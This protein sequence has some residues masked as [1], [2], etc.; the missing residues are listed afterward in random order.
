MSGWS[1]GSDQVQVHVG[2]QTPVH[3]CTANF[4][5]NQQSNMEKHAKQA[6]VLG[7]VP[8]GTN[9]GAC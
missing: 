4:P 8:A 3:T 2:E 1:D 9:T 6:K 5:P 7:C